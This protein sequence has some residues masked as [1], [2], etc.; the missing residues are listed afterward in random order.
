MDSRILFAAATVAAFIAAPTA[1]AATAAPA[2]QTDIVAVSGAE[3]G[4]PPAT[5]QTSVARSSD[6]E[7]GGGGGGAPT[8]LGRLS[9]PNN[10]TPN[11]FSTREGFNADGRPTPAFEAQLWLYLPAVNA[12]VGL[13][14]PPGVDI[15]VN[16]PRPTLADVAK[17]LSFAFDCECTVRYGDFVGEVS[18]LYVATKEKTSFPPTPPLL[19]QAVLNSKVDVIYVSPGIGYRLLRTN[20]LSIDARVGFTYAALDTDAEFAAGRF[21]ASRSFTPSFTQAWLGERID[22]YPSP[23]WR[24]E[25]TAAITAIGESRNGWNAK[26]AVS[27]LVNKWVDVTLGYMGSQLNHD[28]P[29]ARDGSN[30]SASILLYGPMAALGVRF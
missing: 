14:R 23:H 18:F 1:H 24:I 9:A 7:G 6:D 28:E 22:Y 17:S 29:L 4:A 16:R 10:P 25:S 15:N 3:D 12:T 8:G 30:R 5:A 26:F 27:Y 20:N 19:P 11:L 13:G 21:A 2:P